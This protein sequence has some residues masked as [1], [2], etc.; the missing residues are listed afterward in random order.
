MIRVLLADD[1][2]VLTD[3][4]RSFLEKEDGIEVVG[5]AR[6]GKEALRFLENNPTDVV[7]LDIEMEEMG[8]IEATGLIKEKFPQ[9]RVLIL[10]M[11]EEKEY[12]QKALEAGA[13]G[14]VLKDSKKE[15]LVGAI[16]TVHG[17]ASYIPPWLPLIFIPGPK[18]QESEIHPT[19]RERIV[20]QL[21]ANGLAAKEIAARLDI[22]E[23][24][25]RTHI[26]NLREK[27]GV[28]NVVQLVTA[29]LKRGLVRLE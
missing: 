28:S 16:H 14:Y 27:F 18:K 3:G 19:E 5:E 4:I 23:N 11:F 10:S 2:Q 20:L 9:S 1:H 25:V 21:L 13:D 24:T 17:G 29:A 12:V 7:V 15:A 22:G 8:G 26:R 6:N